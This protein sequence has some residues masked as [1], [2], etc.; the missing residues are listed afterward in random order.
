M[1]IISVTLLYCS[2]GWQL[3]RGAAAPVLCVYTG[4]SQAQYD[5]MHLNASCADVDG[6]S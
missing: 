4:G 6:P 3:F 1:E 5:D 2:S